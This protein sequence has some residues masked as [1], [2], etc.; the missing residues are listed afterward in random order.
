MNAARR[1]WGCF[2][3]RADTRLDSPADGGTNTGSTVTLQ[4]KSVDPL[5][6]STLT[7]FY[8]D[9]VATFTTPNLQTSSQVAAKGGQTASWA[10]A[11][12]GNFGW[13]WRARTSA[14]VG[15]TAAGVTGTYRV[16]VS[17]LGN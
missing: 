1:F 11:A 15:G 16:V 5:C 12:L 17:S 8:M 3:G 7:T 2:V 10:S 4:A 13:Y 14:A 6:R 9:R